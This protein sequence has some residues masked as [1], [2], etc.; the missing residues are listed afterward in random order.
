MGT[1]IWYSVEKGYGLILLDNSNKEVFVHKSSISDK[2]KSLQSGQRVMFSLKEGTPDSLEMEKTAHA[3]FINSLT[4]LNTTTNF[5][6]YA[7]HGS[8]ELCQNMKLTPNYL[9]D[10]VCPYLKAIAE[11][12]EVIDE[13]C[14]NANQLLSIRSISQNSPINV[15]FDGVSKA[16]QVVTDTVVPWRRK[17]SETMAQILEQD[18]LIDI[19]HKTADISEKRARAM[20]ERAEADKLA[21][22]A[23]TQREHA[24]RMKIENDKLRL[25]LQKEKIQMAL[26]FII[27]I[28]PDITE[29]EKIT[30]VVKVLMPIDVLIESDLQI[31]APK[32]SNKSRKI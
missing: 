25:N 9:A 31:T 19:K 11:L 5:V 10:A 7:E 30:Y 2:D 6:L 17:H 13:V 27:Q 28:K 23:A 18:K 22:E 4:T 1:V 29:T 15:S 3:E 20:K 32:S 21:A 24:E 8:R 12:Q 26:D 16:L 14:G